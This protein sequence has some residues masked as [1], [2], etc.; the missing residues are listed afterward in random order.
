MRG[1][2][3]VYPEHHAPK[4][5]HPISPNFQLYFLN[6]SIV[7]NSPFQAFS[8]FL[9]HPSSFVAQ[10]KLKHLTTSQNN[11]IV[12]LCGFFSSNIYIF[13][14][15]SHE[16]KDLFHQ[17][18]ILCFLVILKSPDAQMPSKAWLCQFGFF[19]FLIGN[20]IRILQGKFSKIMIQILY[21]LTITPSHSKHF[22]HIGGLQ[23]IAWQQGLVYS[24]LRQK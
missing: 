19:S 3:P 17:K 14:K 4:P 13:D 24:A 10:N 21:R 22:F 7:F 2:T 20:K 8:S 6:F 15:F 18:K 9:I 16:D 1:S 12:M 5:S 23:G 11:H